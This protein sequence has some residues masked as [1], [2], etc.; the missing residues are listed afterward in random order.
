MDRAAHSLDSLVFGSLHFGGDL[1]RRDMSGTQEVKG[2][3]FFAHAD[4][5]V[6]SKIDA[7]NGAIGI[8]P[9]SMPRV[10]FSSEYPIYA[11]DSKV[12]LPEYVKLLFR[13][14]SFRVRINSLISGASGRKRVEP[15]TLESIEVPLPPLGT[16]Q[17]IVAHWR[18]AQE[19]IAATAKSADEHDAAIRKN[20]LEALGLPAKVK[21]PT[22]RV[23]AARWSDV[24]AWSGKAVHLGLTRGDMRKGRF[25][26]VKGRG[27]L[28]SVQHG[29][30]LGPSPLPT[31]LEV[32]KI[33]AATR[34]EYDR[35][36]RKFIADNPQIRRNFDLQANDVL[37]CRT[38]GTL[39]YV[40][41][42]ALVH[43]D[44]PDLIFPDKLIRVRTMDTMEPW[45]LW[46]VLQ[47]PALRS[48]IETAARTAVGNYAI[49]GTDIWNFDFPLPP[50]AIQ[51][52]LVAE[53]AAARE[54]IAAH[55]TAAAKLAA[56]TSREVEE[57]ILGHRP[58]PVTKSKA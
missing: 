18:E 34:G 5:V 53:V 31:S 39:A 10:V 29:C 6:Y 21:G 41:M 50:L 44:E 26:V 49:G 23:F 20:F 28:V 54:R 32:L 30:S 38:N 7:R 14:D 52:K 8:V 43:E 16:Q 40:G 37:M 33:S 51:K 47:T 9:E 48:Q 42:S 4:D 25:P 24:E 58:P 27:C 12:A 36:Q 13:M 17:A 55:R 15:T 3:L 22:P 56:D 1:S 2:R 35:N 19:K 11:V 45:F 57:M 46:L